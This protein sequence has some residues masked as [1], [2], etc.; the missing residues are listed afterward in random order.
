MYS[1]RSASSDLQLEDLELSTRTRNV[2]RQLGCSTLGS[3]AQREYGTACRGLGRATRAEVASL[4]LANGFDPPAS[5]V[6]DR[7]ATDEIAVELL[8]R[9]AEM[10]ADI[11]K[12]LVRIERIRAQILRLALTV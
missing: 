1:L 4:L 11:R 3:V 9:C 5:L 8:E 2:L 7:A 10:E 6:P 12:W